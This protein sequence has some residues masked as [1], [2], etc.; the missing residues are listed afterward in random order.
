MGSGLTGAVDPDPNPY[1]SLH[2]H[3][4]QEPD[5][6]IGLVIRIPDPASGTTTQ[7]RDPNPNLFENA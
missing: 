6:Q 7:S 1:G 4:D 3:A 5:V 2:F